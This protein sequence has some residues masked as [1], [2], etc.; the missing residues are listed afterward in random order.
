MRIEP[1]H[2]THSEVD[3]LAERVNA[4]AIM[5]RVEGASD[6]QM[7]LWMRSAL[8]GMLNQEAETE[9]RYDARAMQRELDAHPEWSRP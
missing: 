6:D 5:S 9:P 8:Y 1:K 2:L 3:A 7:Q 4:I